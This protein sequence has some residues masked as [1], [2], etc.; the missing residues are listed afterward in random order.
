MQSR[1]RWRAVLPQALALWL[2]RQALDHAHPDRV[3]TFFRI[4]AAARLRQSFTRRLGY[5]HDSK[6]AQQ[7][8]SKWLTKGGWLYNAAE[9]SASEVVAFANVA[10]VAPELALAAIEAA[11][12]TSSGPAF[13]S[14]SNY[15]RREWVALL[16]CLAYDPALFDR[17]AVLLIGFSAAELLERPNASP[18]SQFTGLFQLRLSG[19]H[20]T[21]EQRAALIRALLASP[22]TVHQQLGVA[23]LD[24][25]LDARSFFGVGCYE[26]GAHPRDYG[27]R[28]RA[29]EDI[30]G[31]Y[32]AAL[33]VAE[34]YAVQESPLNQRVRSILAQHIRELW[35]HV[36]LESEVEQTINTIASKSFW[37][38]GWFQVLAIVHYES[39]TLSP[40]AAKTL[41]VLEQQLRPH[42]LIQRVRAY[43]LTPSRVGW[44]IFSDVSDTSTDQMQA[45]W[46]RLDQL[47]QDLGRQTAADPDA[48]AALLSDLVQGSIIRGVS[49]GRGLAEA[50]IDLAQAW[51][52]L[53]AQLVNADLKRRNLQVL[54]GFLNEAHGRDSGWVDQI[55]DAAL[56]DA[57]L[58]AWYPALQR[59]VELDVR[60][61]ERLQRAMK[62][63]IAPAA[64]YEDLFTLQL[65]ELVSPS[66]LCAL[67]TAIADMPDGYE[68]AV[69]AFNAHLHS[70]ISAGTAL[71]S[72]LIKCGREL[73]ASFFSSNHSR[74]VDHC[75]GEIARIC[76]DGIDAAADTV[77]TCGKL[78]EA[79]QQ[80]RIRSFEYPELLKGLLV[81]Q[82]LILL[83]ELLGDPRVN[84]RRIF[85]GDRDLNQPA[86]LDVIPP[87]MLV[88][89]AQRNPEVRFERLASAIAPFQNTSSSPGIVWSPLA[90]R[91]L[92]IAPDRVAVLNNYSKALHPM[93]WGGSLADILE[94]RRALPQALFANPDPAVAAWARQVDGELARIATERRVAERQEDES[95]E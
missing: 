50:A 95:F 64:A 13:L 54:Y 73:V 18:P 46:H 59:S 94:Q 52:Q 23:A 25:M 43:V 4:K 29:R 2:A 75:L 90:L 30:V 65:I 24:Q 40:D 63:G 11:L 61:I 1:S 69:C 93:S 9:I 41:S 38:E 87:D 6:P 60:A 53:A 7:I 26:F 10:P 28:P 36:G 79:I 57:V 8:V 20:A 21:I 14:E 81:A 84:A 3:E 17:A 31:W 80:H 19:T 85:L 89:W 78:K 32:A 82:P 92:D 48:F 91:L 67:V 34:Q 42:N 76:L 74:S 72:Q 86:F 5:L 62:V 77:D 35:I 33:G 71:Q 66:R 49:F 51:Q 45:T 83:D 12:H 47:A 56:S 68:V 58:G 37:P 88:E 15:Q 22:N 16:T 44:E 55:L 27:W 39:V 70:V